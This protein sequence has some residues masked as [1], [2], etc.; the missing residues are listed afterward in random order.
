ML[1][2]YGSKVGNLER[3]S[4]G[5]WLRYHHAHLGGWGGPRAAQLETPSKHAKI[6]LKGFSG[7][8]GSV[9]GHKA[10]STGKE[11]AAWTQAK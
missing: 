4:L 6:Y 9:E 2:C 3:N 10:D 5:C 8:M 11:A 1:H 7:A